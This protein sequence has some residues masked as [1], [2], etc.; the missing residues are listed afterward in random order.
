MDTPGAH[1]AL[2]YFKS[3]TFAY[4]NVCEWYTNIVEDDFAMTVRGICSDISSK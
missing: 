2:H 4:D 1:P 3:T